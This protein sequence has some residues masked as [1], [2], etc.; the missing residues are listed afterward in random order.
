MILSARDLFTLQNC[1]RRFLL[2]TSFRVLRWRTKSLLDALLRRSLLV[3]SQGQAV[4]D[5]AKSAKADFLQQAA[6]PG[7][8][9]PRGTDSYKICMD[10]C[11]MLDTILR[12]MAKGIPKLSEPTPITLSTELSWELSCFAAEDGTLHRFITADRWD[13]G[14]LAR[15]LHSW[16]V[17]GDIAV[18]RKPLTLHIVEI[19]Q[20]KKNRQQS[21]W[22]RGWMH[23]ALSN[24]KMHFLKKD[25]SPLRGW[26]PRYLADDPHADPDIWVEQMIRERAVERLT[27]SVIVDVPAEGICEGIVRD[28][29][30]EGH[31]A[32]ELRGER[33]TRPWSEVPMSRGAC[34]GLV[35]CPWQPVCYTQ[36]PVEIERMG[37]Y[38]AREAK[39]HA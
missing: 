14:A 26:R 34:D 35:T 32:G 22:C 38:T 4:G 2:E 15:E 12:A 10:H 11:A 8:A 36:I 9:V 33:S 25:G 18:A 7:L 39:A 16:P 20:R 30:Q 31:R 29:L 3:I 23:P 13:D 27:H 28:I 5:A 24:L 6:N 37:L 19:G 21:L 17:L 1:P